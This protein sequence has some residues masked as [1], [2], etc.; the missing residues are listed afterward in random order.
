MGGA[1]GS[2]AAITMSDYAHLQTLS[3]LWFDARS[4]HLFSFSSSFAPAR[5]ALS[6]AWLHL[7][8]QRLAQANGGS[9]R[10][11]PFDRPLPHRLRQGCRKRPSLVAWTV[12][13][14]KIALA[15][16]G[17]FCSI[18]AYPHAFNP[19]S[20]KAKDESC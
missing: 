5:P 17:R 20:D 7:R 1:E 6:G 18:R 12:H 2:S 16:A 4:C 11:M 14:L 10:L 13:S 15:S 19:S 9:S 8:Y 3:R